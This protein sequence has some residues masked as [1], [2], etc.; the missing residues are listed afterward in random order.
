[1]FIL[2]SDFIKILFCDAALLTGRRLVEGGAYF[3]L[4]VK[5]STSYWRV[6]LIGGSMFIR[7]VVE[8]M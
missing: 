5:R 3:D 6:G 7:G 8:T 4:S 2:W 1:M